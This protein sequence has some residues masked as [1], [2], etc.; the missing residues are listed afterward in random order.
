MM[1]L[2]LDNILSGLNLNNGSSPFVFEA[3]NIDGV[4]K[5]LKTVS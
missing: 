1:N 2:N 5:F 4:L 3:T